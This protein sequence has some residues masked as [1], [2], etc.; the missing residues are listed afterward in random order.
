MLPPDRARLHLGVLLLEHGLDLRFLIGGEIE[1]RG[2][3]IH[4]LRRRFRGDPPGPG[5]P[6]GTSGA[7]ASAAPTHRAATANKLIFMGCSETWVKAAAA[8]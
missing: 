8:T 2:E 6:G 5:P 3:V 4:P 1:K 7:C